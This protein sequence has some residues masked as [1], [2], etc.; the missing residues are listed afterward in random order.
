LGASTPITVTVK[1]NYGA[2]VGSGY[3]VN[4]YRGATVAGGTLISTATTGSDSTAVVTAVSA[5]GA[6]AGASEQYSV[7]VVPPTGAAVPDNAF[8]T[9]VYTATGNITSLSVAIA[10]SN[11]D[12][13]TAIGNDDTTITDTEATTLDKI[14]VVTVPTDGTATET[15]A[16]TE[17]YDISNA[18]VTGGGI[19]S[20]TF[21]LAANATDDNSATYTTSEG[22]FVATASGTAWNAGKTSLEVA[23]GTV[24]YV[25]ATKVGLHTVTVTS[26]GKSVPIK[27]W[28]KNAQTDYYTLSASAGATSLLPSSNSVVTITVKDVFGNVVDT[29]AN[30]LT[31]TAAD[32]VRLAGQALTQV[33][34]TGA[35]G[36]FQFTVIA[37]GSTGTGTITI[38]PTTTGAQAWATG[39]TKPTGAADPVKSVTVTFTVAGTTAKSAEVLAS[40]AAEAEAKKATTE[41]A[42]ATKTA[43]EAKTEAAAATT[44]AKAGTAAAK[45]AEAAAKLAETA[46]T[47]AGTDAVAAAKLAETAATKAGTDAVA[48]AAAAGVK[49][50]DAKASADAATDAAL[51]AIDAANAA[52]DAAN[53][54]GEAA[55]AATVAAEDAVGVAQEARDAALEALDAANA[56]TEAATTASEAAYAAATAAEEARDAALEAIDAATLAAEAADAATEAADQAREAAEAATA[57]VEALASQVS[58]LMAALRA[59]LTTVANVV[60]KIAKKVKA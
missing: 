39:Y 45:L 51:E 9:I 7:Q 42:L 20:D 58:T 22:A 8:A 36:T 21:R 33:M 43:G 29:A 50:D 54:A 47:K 59:Q 19:S 35:D 4:L 44:E 41:A 34:E 30:L 38:A 1:T 46:A 26:G 11:G 25:F 56:A 14:P 17:I 15:A 55:D 6:A 24:V 16:Q 13:A 31:A 57:A 18:A 37:D 27:F 53:L 2:L 60:A 3:V 28:A 12:L 5:A 32:K 23:E 48:A 40:E 52:T 49:A 10:G